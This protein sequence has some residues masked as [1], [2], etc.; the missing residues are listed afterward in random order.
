MRR[1]ALELPVEIND[2]DFETLY[3]KET[4]PRLKIRLLAM[5]HLKAG[6]H[7][8]EVAIMVKAHETSVLLWIRRFRAGGIE[9]LREKGGRGR[10]LRLKESQYDKF[11]QA[12][13]KAQ[14]NKKGGRIKGTD[15]MQL[16]ETEFQVKLSLSRVYDLLHKVNLSWISSRSKHPK[17]NKKA[18]EAFKKTSNNLH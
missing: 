9:G 6:V 10:A 8:K 2:H 12:V 18:Q 14:V 4:H 1:P 11:K 3:R 13:I 7:Y 17:Q 15:I 16:L 5:A